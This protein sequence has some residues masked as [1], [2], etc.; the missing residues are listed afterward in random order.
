MASKSV[1]GPSVFD[2]HVCIVTGGGTGIGKAIAFELAESGATVII[3]S[4]NMQVL[5]SAAAS[6]AG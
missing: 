4:R 1:F 2:G 6:F 3:A 5:E